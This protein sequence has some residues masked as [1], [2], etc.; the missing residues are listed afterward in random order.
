MTIMSFPAVFFDGVVSK[1][2]GRDPRIS[3]FGIIV[4]LSRRLVELFEHFNFSKILRST[5]FDARL[6]YLAY[7]RAQ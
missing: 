7:S 6:Y 3:N 2:V 5:E 1:S 4:P